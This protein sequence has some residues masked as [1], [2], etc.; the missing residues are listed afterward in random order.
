[1]RITQQIASA[2]CVALLAVFAA[3]CSDGEGSETQGAQP[4]LR[5]QSIAEG[6]QVAVASPS[7][8]LEYSVP[9]SVADASGIC[10]NG[11]PVAATTQGTKLIVSLSLQPRTEYTFTLSAHALARYGE[12][13]N[14]APALSI[15]FQTGGLDESPVNGQATSSAKSV[16]SYL[17]GQY[18]QRTL[19]GVMANVNNN[20][21]YADLVFQSVGKH[22]ALTCYDFVH[23]PYSPANWVDYSDIT[24]AETQWKAGG[25]VSYMW[26]WNVPSSEGEADLSK[27]G[28][29]APGAN[30][31]S[32]ETDFDI[33]EALKEGTWQRAVIEADVAKVAATL[34]LL[35]DKG[36][37]VL[38]RPL[39]EAAGNY[40]T[41]GS[42]AWF[43]WGR[44]GTDYTR[45]LW[46]W[47][48]DKLVGEYGLDNLIWVWTVQVKEGHVQDALAA[49]PGDGYVDLVAADIYEDNTASK[50]TAFDFVN[51]VGGGKKMVALSECGNVPNPAQCYENGDTWSWFMVWYGRNSDGTLKLDGG[52][53]H[54][55]LEYWKT[56]AESPRVVWREDMPKHE[57]YGE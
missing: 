4:E 6:A 15:R 11:Q 54:M 26:H 57:G 12:P 48:Y 9:V 7:L 52:W 13:Q 42:G 19:S 55:T 46:Q 44:Y 1:M 32:G 33:R 53:S 35:Q 31:G 14:F 38:W 56:L 51:Q 37:A 5:S 29:Y 36:I 47:M 18:G 22:P 16:Y 49:Y 40:G 45:R 34:K 25:L 41:N 30:G 39:H 27:Y 50:R 8:E 2:L 10:L 23:L 43:W 17:L 28:F 3:A 20:N 21:E 24:P